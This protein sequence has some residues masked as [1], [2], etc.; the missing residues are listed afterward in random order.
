MTTA[1]ITRIT[2]DDLYRRVW[3]TPIRTLA[4][5]FG[6]SDV[7]LAKICD[8]HQIPRPAAGHWSKKRHG[9]A[10]EQ[11][12]LAEIDDDKLQTIEISVWDRVDG[13]CTADPVI[14]ELILAESDPAQQI[15]V[16]DRLQ[17]RHPF[18]KATQESLKR[19]DLNDYGRVQ[20][21]W[22]VTD[23]QFEVQVSR[24]NVSR[25]LRI[26]QAL[27]TAMEGRGYALKAGPK[28]AYRTKNWEPYFEVLGEQFRVTLREKSTR[29]RRK[30]DPA[31]DGR[32][33]GSQYE[34]TPTG[35]MELFINFGS[36]SND[37]AVRDTKNTRLE[38]RLNSVVS[39]ML[40]RVDTRRVQAERARIAAV[41]KAERKKVAVEEE[42]ERRSDSARIER[43]RNLLQQWE[44]FQRYR[45]FVDVVRGEI[46]AMPV[47]DRET[48]Y[49]LNWA[50]QFLDQI[51]PLAGGANLPTYSL[52]EDEREHLRRE[53]EAD[54]SDYSETFRRSD[55]QS[56]YS[57]PTTP[58]KPR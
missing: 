4:A 54:W 13:P 29:S 9:K 49:W 51:D 19:G 25:A 28:P 18:V 24:E 56:G 11:T 40:Q 50:D 48:S 12:P 16:N 35:N 57:R 27:T 21:N 26:L 1:D 46:D 47:A 10:V 37:G 34:Y 22:P 52:S 15:T 58:G 45:A 55:R 36:Y 17:L 6:V 33:Y 43:L 20:Q 14:A 2:R 23:P 30:P 3:S 44:T 8:R 31:K 32:W 7:G 5:E 41:A 42:I 53:C 38:E 39:S